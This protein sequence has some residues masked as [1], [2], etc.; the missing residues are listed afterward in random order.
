MKRKLIIS[1]LFIMILGCLFNVNVRAESYNPNLDLEL[2]ID[3]SELNNNTIKIDVTSINSY[4]IS[5]E[6]DVK[7]IEFSLSPYGTSANTYIESIEVETE[8][9]WEYSN[10]G[11]EV[12]FKKS[13][14]GEFSLGKIQLYILNLQKIEQRRANMN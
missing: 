4:D 8:N 1:I 7:T 3:Q 2:T 14:D 6:N 5:Y 9:E 11:Q 10:S 13:Y 12:D